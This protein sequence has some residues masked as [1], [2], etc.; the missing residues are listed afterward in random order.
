M[1]IPDPLRFALTGWLAGAIGTVI[2]GVIWPAIFPGLIHPE[3]YYA[4]AVLGIPTIV[5]LTLLWTALPSILGGLGGGSLI[6]EGG[7]RE[8]L[9]MAVIGSLV[10]TLPV[11]AFHLWLFSGG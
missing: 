7:R 6:R 9:I 11:G 3:H 10:L 8:Q 5:G 1:K 2:L 4:G